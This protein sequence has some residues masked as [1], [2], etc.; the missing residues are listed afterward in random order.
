ME[1]SKALLKQISGFS[2]AIL[3]QLL[4]DFVRTI[5]GRQ[6]LDVEF[7]I[8]AIFVIGSSMCVFID[9]WRSGIRKNVNQKGILNFSPAG[10][11]VLVL[12]IWIIFLPV[13]L[14]K[15]KNMIMKHG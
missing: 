9:A 14:I 12:F 5:T 15:R 13:Y 7:I 6:K 11:G 8:V 2:M 10:W 3:L 1:E 4:I